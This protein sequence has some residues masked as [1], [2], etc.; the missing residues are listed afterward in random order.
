MGIGKT[1][2]LLAVLFALCGEAPSGLVLDDLI[3]TSCDHTL[4]RVEGCLN[5]LPFFIERRKR[6]GGPVAVKTDLPEQLKIDPKIFVDGRDNRK[7]IF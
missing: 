4:V 1:S 7:R 6:R 5:N 2:R 3:N